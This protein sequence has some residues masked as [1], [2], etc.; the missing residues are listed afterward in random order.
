M[1]GGRW[2]AP[3]FRSLRIRMALSHGAVLAAIVVLLGGAGYA[4]L[5]R[6][7][8]ARATASV[9][10]AARETMEHSE[11]GPATPPIDRDVPSSSAIQVAL[12]GPNGRPTDPAIG[13][14]PWL[15]PQHRQIATIEALGE[16]VRIA[17]LP[18]R[19][20]GRLIATVVAGRSLVPEDELLDRVQLLLLL[21]GF[22]AVLA[23]MGAGWVLAG[24]AVRPVHRAY[25]A[26]TNFAA[27]ASHELRTPLAFVRSAVEVMA[28]RDP[29]LGR[30]VLA[31]IDYLSGLTDR[32]LSMA[33]AD[34]GLLALEQRRVALGQLCERVVARHS[35]VHGLRVWLPSPPHP[36]G[37]PTVMADPVALEAVLDA[38]L[39]NVAVHGGGGVSVSFATRGGRVMLV[40]AD[41]GPGLTADERA[42]AFE[43]FYRSDP[44]RGH[45]R[46]GA[47]LGLALARELVIAQ[48][49]RVRLEETP[50]GGL[51]VLIELPATPPVDSPPKS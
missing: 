18:V 30:D 12:F 2:R 6:S 3:M 41:R 29:S 15:R 47:G 38:V 24:R 42:Q 39:E 25:E 9:L 22:A 27:D 36:D 11:D 23:S 44:A 34:S 20:E 49:G 26:R 4:S 5:A 1:D 46:G 8:D 16:P 33:R 21:G 40:V 35:K 48:R 51:T 13:V 7:Q 17:T 32:L 19:R 45:D 43:R 28:E 31:E 50:G 10:D 37:G 14:P